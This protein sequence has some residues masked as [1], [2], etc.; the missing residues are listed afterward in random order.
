[1]TF[2]NPIRC[3]TKGP[4]CALTAYGAWIARSHPTAPI[5]V[6]IIRPTRGQA[7]DA[8]QVEWEAWA[9]LIDRLQEERL[10]GEAKT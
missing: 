4:L 8:Y 2:K 10:E 9:L 1:M 5:S 6:A 7:E 3:W